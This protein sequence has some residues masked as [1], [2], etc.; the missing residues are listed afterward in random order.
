MDETYY[1]STIGLNMG[2]NGVGEMD[3]H[4]PFA[5]VAIPKTLACEGQSEG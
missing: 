3:S 2:E 1:E 4:F 5:V